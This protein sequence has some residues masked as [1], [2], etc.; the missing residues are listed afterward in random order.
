MTSPLK[1]PHCV[2][3]YLAASPME[4]IV[5]DRLPMFHSKIANVVK[6]MPSPIWEWFMAPIYGDL[7]DGLWWFIIVSTTLFRNSLQ[8]LSVPISVPNSK[9]RRRYPWT[10]HGIG[11]QLNLFCCKPAAKTRNKIPRKHMLQ[12]PDLWLISCVG[13]PLFSEFHWTHFAQTQH[14][15]WHC[16]FSQFNRQMPVLSAGLVGTPSF[17]GKLGNHGR[18]ANRNDWNHL[19]SIAWCGYQ[20]TTCSIPT[21]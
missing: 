12:A 21:T 16:A 1:G 14:T 13:P 3:E 19:K 4:G 6:T 9:C 10:D 18:D 11:I 20:T 15:L 17:R 7:G 2:E 5:L 8:T